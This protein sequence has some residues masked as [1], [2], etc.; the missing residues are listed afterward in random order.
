[1]NQTLRDVA[2]ELRPIVLEAK[3]G[4]GKIPC[5]AETIGRWKR[6]DF[7]RPPPIDQVLTLLDD[8]NI[9][10]FIISRNS[11]IPY[12]FSWTLDHVEEL[13]ES[14]RL[15]DNRT[16]DN[17][18]VEEL[19]HLYESDCPDFE[20]KLHIGNRSISMAT[21]VGLNIRLEPTRV[22]FFQDVSKFNSL[23]FVHHICATW[24]EFMKGNFWNA[25]VFPKGFR[26]FVVFSQ[27]D[28]LQK[29]IMKHMVDEFKSGFDEEESKNTLKFHMSSW[30]EKIKDCMIKETPEHLRKFI[31]FY[32]LVE[33]THP[34][35]APDILLSLL[36]LPSL[37][38][39]FQSGL[40]GLTQIID[41][42]ELGDCVKGRIK[43]HGN[44]RF[45]F[46]PE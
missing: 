2:R 29:Q 39:S 9:R 41:P 35:A 21:Q 34:T 4:H 8:D 28:Y 11:T 10:D 37:T 33:L 23:D 15:G 36:R 13:R 7:A 30:T 45:S 3:T 46:I 14:H 43:I 17:P 38:R 32:G 18:R 25:N 31:Y 20:T 40:L 42:F 27:K 1:L 22:L 6:L 16:E 19:L 24:N 5:D 26:V 44:P 12:G